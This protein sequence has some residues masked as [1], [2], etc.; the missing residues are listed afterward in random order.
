[1]YCVVENGGEIGERKGVNVPNVEIGL[2]AITERD[3]QDILFGL[4]EGIDYIAASFI[5]DGNAVR[6]IRK[7]CDEN[8]GEYVGIFPKIECA[9]AIKNFDD[10][11]KASQGVMVARGDLGIEIPAELVPHYQKTIIAKCNAAYKRSSP[12]RRCSTRCSATRARR[13]PRSPTSPTPS[14]TE[15]TP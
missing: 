15:P 6:E 3:R 10:I 11:L 8:G 4:S 5:R 9:M 12:P 14:T 2:P 7:L 1:M 13:A